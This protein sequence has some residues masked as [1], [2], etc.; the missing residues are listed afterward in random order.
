[1]N[2]YQRAANGSRS[3]FA[4]GWATVTP[5]RSSWNSLSL[6]FWISCL[7][8]WLRWNFLTVSSKFQ[9]FNRP[10]QS[11]NDNLQFTNDSHSHSRFTTSTLV[12]SFFGD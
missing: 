11:A 10:L 2:R 8:I 9:N 4:T 5:V 6:K 3:K 12:F 7:P 1:M